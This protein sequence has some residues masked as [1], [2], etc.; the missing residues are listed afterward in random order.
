[1]Y[2]KWRSVLDTIAERLRGGDASF[3]IHSFLRT[4]T[5]LEGTGSK[6]KTIRKMTYRIYPP[7]SLSSA[8]VTL[9]M[10][11]KTRESMCAVE[12]EGRGGDGV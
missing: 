1:M 4:Y 8:E 3:S 10:L 6:I 11:E 7:P 2:M 9:S 5:T 12:A